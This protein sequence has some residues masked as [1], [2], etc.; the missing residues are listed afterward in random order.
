[1]L[2]C[3]QNHVHVL[4]RIRIF[5]ASSRFRP[6][7]PTTKE[8]GGNFIESNRQDPGH[9]D[10]L[11][12]Q[13]EDEPFDPEDPAFFADDGEEEA[14]QG[15][16][17]WI[18]RGI[19]GIIAIVFLGNVLAFLPQFF[20]TAAVQ[21]LRANYRLSQ[22]EQIRQYKQ[23]IVVVSAGDRKGTGFNIASEGKI[24]TNQHV[25]GDE[26]SVM[27]SFPQGK[28]YK[29]TVIA[30]DS[31]LDLAVLDIP[32]AGTALPVLPLASEASWREGDPV[33]VIGNP[34]F[35]NLIAN[36]GSILGI[37]SLSGRNQP[38]MMIQAPI[39]KG[40]SG[41]PVIDRN[42]RVIGVVYA[43]MRNKAKGNVGLA[44]PIEYLEHLPSTP[45]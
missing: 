23:A 18:K 38:V 42:G 7:Q 6:G 13:A 3:F 2:Q 16:P 5:S 36:E 28:I 4:V 29:A 1:M 8:R 40:N 34:L 31:E 26:P 14:P 35:F 25:V 21:F 19:A 20:N 9:P 44:V 41:S 30:S 12:N 43:T 11:Q 22:N 32:E 27:V 39:Y 24:V 33:Y 37:T 17:A 15:M 10:H 45:D